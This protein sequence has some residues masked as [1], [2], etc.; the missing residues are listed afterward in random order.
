MAVDW[1]RMFSKMFSGESMFQNI[2]TAHGAGM[3]AFGSSFPGQIKADRH[4]SRPRYDP[5]EERLSGRRAGSG[6]VH[7][8]QP[9]AGRGPLRRRGLHHA[10]A[11]AATA[12]PLPRSTATLVEYDLAS[13]VSRS[14]WTPATW[15]ASPPGCRWRYRSGSRHE[16]QAVGRRG[17]FQHRPHRSRTYLA[18]DHAHLRR[19]RRPAAL[20]PHRQQ[21]SCPSGPQSPSLRAWQIFLFFTQ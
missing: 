11:S 15:R 9:A 4:H 3:I 12:W 7:P 16:E 20:Y 6:A 17:P 14:W 13:R 2:Y 19:G 8:L 21:L 5:P 1:G 10:D 18:A